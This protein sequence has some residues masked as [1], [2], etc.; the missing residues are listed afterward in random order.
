MDKWDKSESFQMMWVLLKHLDNKHHLIS[1]VKH[2]GGSVMT[3]RLFAA[4]GSGWLAITEEIMKLALDQRLLKESFGSSAHEL[5]SIWVMQ[6]DD[7]TKYPSKTILV[8]GWE[9]TNVVFWRGQVKV[10]TYT[11][12]RCCDLKQAVHAR[13]ATIVVELKQLCMDEWAKIPPRPSER[14]IMNYRK[15]LV[16]VMQLNMVQQVRSQLLFS[17]GQWLLHNFV[18]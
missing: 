10:Q 1:A 14:L 6:Q 2:V 16:T 12:W 15:C 8:C 11:H 5:K 4:S 13:E 18:N 9:E 3:Q 7:N 17:Q